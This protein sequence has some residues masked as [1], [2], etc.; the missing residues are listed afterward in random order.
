MALKNLGTVKAIHSGSTPPSN[1]TMLWY[2][3][4]INAYTRYKHH[5]YD[6]NLS[7]WRE[8][9]QEFSINQTLLNNATTYI[10]I[11]TTP[12]H[13]LIQAKF[14]LTRGASNSATGTIEIFNDE[15]SVLISEPIGR[16][17]YGDIDEVGESAITIGVGYNGS[18]IRLVI[19]CSN[20]GSDASI[21]LFSIQQIS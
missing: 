4:G 1:I 5:Y 7:Q 20:T 21:N 16:I 17:I 13:H 10:N 9:N 11:G 3:T 12:T 8:L 14:K 18:N 15:S 2:N 19:V 6:T